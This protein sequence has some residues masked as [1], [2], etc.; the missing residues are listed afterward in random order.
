MKEDDLYGAMLD[1]FL[2]GKLRGKIG[3][4][5]I[6]YH[7]KDDNGTFQGGTVMDMSG[8]QLK[9]IDFNTEG[10][11]MSKAVYINGKL[12]E[13]SHRELN[14]TKTVR[15]IEKEYD[16]TGITYLKLEDH[17][18]ISE[19]FA[20]KKL[21][22]ITKRDHVGYI[23]YIEFG[24]TSDFDMDPEPYVPQDFVS[25]L[26]EITKFFEI[27][28][29]EIDYYDQKG[30]F[31]IEYDSEVV[32]LTVFDQNDKKELFAEFDNTGRSDVQFSIMPELEASIF[33]TVQFGNLI[34]LEGSS[35]MV[36]IR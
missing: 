19:A 10:G 1:G 4:D 20:K 26:Q 2:S 23:L 7:A 8:K 30:S 3:N 27:Q 14:R 22:K 17:G 33:A 15:F 9:R 18:I 21:T 35:R 25:K 31:V 6:L 36:K 24:P 12:K 16:D 34:E 11:Y 29:G 32:L 28:D 5:K 13:E